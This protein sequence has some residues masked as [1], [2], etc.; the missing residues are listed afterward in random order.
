[1]DFTYGGD[2]TI[3]EYYLTSTIYRIVQEALNNAIKHGRA[4]TVV[5]ML[6]Q[7]GAMC[8][9]TVQDNGLGIGNMANQGQGIG[10]NIMQYRA[11]M[12]GASLDVR[13]AEFGGTALTCS[14]Q[15]KNDV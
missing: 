12:I 10:L 2:D 14:F 1:M 8:V 5:I 7:E 9:L 13:N 15:N 11:S 6:R 4:D 3:V